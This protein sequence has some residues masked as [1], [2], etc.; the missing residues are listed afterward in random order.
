MI[1]NKIRPEPTAADKF[2]TGQQRNTKAAAAEI[3]RRM[4]QA[5]I[6]VLAV[7]NSI[8]VKRIE[9]SRL[10]AN[11]VSYIY[12]LSA[13]RFLEV[14]LELKRIIASW[15]EVQDATQRPARWF[16]DQYI[17]KAHTDGTGAAL[18]NIAS[19][20]ESV[21]ADPVLLGQVQLENV[22]LS[23]PYRRRF[24]LVSARAFNDM[25]GFA[26]ENGRKLGQILGNGVA[27]GQSPREIARQ[28]YR[29]FDFI[30]GY[31]ALRIA[32]TEVNAAF[33]KAREEA[34]KDARDRLGVEMRVMHVSSLVEGST[35]LHHAER[36]GGI[37]TPEDQSLWWSQGSNRINCLC[38]TVEIVFVDGKPL[39]EA[40]IK[41]T[42]AKGARFLGIEK[43]WPD[44]IQPDKK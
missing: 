10:Q 20:L 40:L 37:F 26:D 23:E 28:L 6:E 21:S 19:A 32:R 3:K 2:P 14:E 30:E 16:F 13:T 25:I 44:G 34:T 27:G 7:F 18:G 43:E 11:Q 4:K 1:I 38:T 17:G 15:L 24:E 41:R 42:R 31:R 35:R 8:P 12:E 33:N 5:K 36:H 9:V 39:Q 22:L 29:E